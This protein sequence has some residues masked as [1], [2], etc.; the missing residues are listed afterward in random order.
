MRTKTGF[1][2][3]LIVSLF[4]G[5]ASAP[6]TRRDERALEA[7]ADAAIASYVA[8]DPSFD[9]L[10]ARSVGYVV[11]PEVA[12]GGFIVGG[13]AGVGVVYERGRPVGYAEL[14]S[15]SIGLQAGGQTYS[16]IV[17]FN[18]HEA[19]ERLMAGNFDLSADL[20]ATAIQSGAAASARFEGGTAVFIEDESGLMAG[21]SLAGESISYQA[22]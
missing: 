21:A 5:C 7:H 8:R 9:D 19:L 4:A 15:G 1:I 11:F 13:S 22:K 20:T 14:R 3:G 16:E 12:T 6:Q 2:V 18:S 10:L 17:V